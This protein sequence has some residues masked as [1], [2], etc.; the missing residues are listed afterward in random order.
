MNR[1]LQELPA[2]RMPDKTNTTYIVRTLKLVLSL[3]LLTAVY[4]YCCTH[5]LLSFH[6]VLKHYIVF[7]WYLPGLKLNLVLHIVFQEIT[8][9]G[10]GNHMGMWVYPRSDLEVVSLEYKFHPALW[11]AYRF[12]QNICLKAKK[13]IIPM[14]NSSQERTRLLAIMSAR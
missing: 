10:L 6:I 8:W 2:K 1:R 3:S 4:N 12:K 14:D 13:V 11:L 7:L 5:L 9:T